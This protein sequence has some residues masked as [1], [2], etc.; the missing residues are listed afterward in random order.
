MRPS[1]N[2]QI[3][4]ES[5]R[6]VSAIDAAQGLIVVLTGAG[7]SLAS[8][9]PT[10]RGSD[11]GAIWAHDVTERATLRYFTSD[12][13]GAWQWYRE[14]FRRV[15]TARP[16]EAHRALA[17][18]ERWHVRQR[19]D[20]LLVTQ[21]ID[22][23]HERAGSTRVVKVHGSADRCRCADPACRLGAVE[24]IPLGDVDFAEFDRDPRIAAIPSCPV[25]GSRVR[26]HVL[27]FDELYV[28]HADYQ[29]HVVDA[30]AARI[31]LL[32]CVGT[33]LAVGVTS[34][35][36]SAAA[37]ARA[38]AFLVDPGERPQDAHPSTVHVRARAE[39]LLPVAYR[40]L[41]KIV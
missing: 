24:S 18:L 38:P 30:A 1:S 4:N 11:P 12:P 20:F 27:W 22:T 5:S 16:N 9:I 25:C 28:S 17:A 7:I 6:L 3:E 15:L 35:L 14:R 8:G 10:F 39:E 13:V 32:I 19:R 41:R 29:W 33:S 31:R 40:I 2:D 37:D 36:Q 34:F 21:N 23:L 26:P